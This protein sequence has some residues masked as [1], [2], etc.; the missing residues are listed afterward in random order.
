METIRKGIE[1]T[2]EWEQ[3]I[4]GVEEDLSAY[5]LSVFLVYPNGRKK[6]VEYTKEDVCRMIVTVL[7]EMQKEL[8][9]YSLE[10]W[11]NRDK[12]KQSVADI[13]NAFELVAKSCDV[14][15]EATGDIRTGY[16]KLSSSSLRTGV[17][18]ESAYQ[19]WLN[20][21]NEGTE[22]DFMNW[23]REPANQ[24]ATQANSAAERANQAAAA[25]ETSVGKVDEALKSVPSAILS[26]SEAA[27]RADAQ[28]DRASAA[29]QEASGIVEEARPLLQSLGQYEDT[30]NGKA[31]FVTLGEIN[32]VNV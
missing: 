12:E 7:P 3:L 14:G 29:A 8:G 31:S 32:E 22:V 6:Q 25:A 23:L 5:D 21:G 2:V 19:T 18:G 4:N 24:G 11:L 1:F 26:A 28:A 16:I 27:A 9:R 17:K 20:Q 10:V 30:L 13:C 15:E